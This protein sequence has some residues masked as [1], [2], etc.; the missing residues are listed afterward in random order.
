MMPVSKAHNPDSAE[1]D[2]L[3][4]YTFH[5]VNLDPRGSHGVG[6]CPFC[7][8]VDKFSVDITTGLWRCFV[9]GTGTT[10]GGGNTLVFV[11]LMYE[12][13]VATLAGDSGRT[14]RKKFLAEVAANRLITPAAVDAWG[15]ALAADGTWLLPGYGT[16][17]KLD[18]VYR[19]TQIKKTDKWEWQL[20]PTPG[21]WSEGRSHALH[22]AIGDF[23]PNRSALV[24]CEGPWDG[25]ALWESQREVWG[26]ANIIAVPGCTTWRDEWTEFCRAKQVTLLY[27]SD[28]PI[29]RA[30]NVIRAGY[31]GMRRVA[32]RLCGIAASVRYVKWG[33]DGYDDTRPTGWDVRDHLTE[34]ADRRAALV[35]LL[36]K[37]QTVPTEWLMAT[38]SS[39]GKHSGITNLEAR[40]CKTWAECEATWKDAMY[41]RNDLSDA[42]AVLLAICASTS[43]SGNQLF[44]DLIGSPGSAKTTL[45]QGLLVSGHCVHVENVTKLMSGWKD[46]QDGSKDCSFLARANGKTWITIEI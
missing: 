15:V 32:R 18:Q 8:H 1:L 6:D 7:G 19:R 26:D 27:D 38:P 24:V 33:N 46:P 30:G 16:D 44:L 40:Q 4:P 14:K 11:R 43:Q 37:V 36:T 21:L 9:C 35:D 39:N 10:A 31:D 28:H 23:N 3:R 42:M 12:R 45:C 41:W 2:R 17:G 34:I 22:M 13:A 5:G 29:T 25:M 20:L